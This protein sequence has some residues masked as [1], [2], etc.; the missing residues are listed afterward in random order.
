MRDERSRKALK[1]AERYADG[2]ATDEEWRAARD[3]A[4]AAA[5]QAHHD[6]YVDEARAQFRID[7]GYVAV[8]AAM[9]AADA[10]LACLG[11]PIFDETGGRFALD[12]GVL[13]PDMLREIFGNPFRLPQIDPYWLSRND[14]AAARMAQSIYDER[15]FD[16]M[17]IL[18]DA[19]EDGGCQDAA[20]LG[21][22][23][24]ADPHV[25]GCWVLD[26]LLGKE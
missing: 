25:P 23:R 16:R 3:N 11:E 21:H 1:T 20:I 7:A 22:C 14:R 15:A 9:R 12:E 24:Q 19:L 13:L 4:E 2:L 26:L 18:A 6:E 17:A 8:C 5:D 10:A